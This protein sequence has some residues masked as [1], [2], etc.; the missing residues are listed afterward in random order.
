MAQL[1][2]RDNGELFIEHNVFTV[3]DPDVMDDVPAE[4]DENGLLAVT[5]CGAAVLCGT[6]TGTIEVTAETWDGSPPLDPSS[7]Q[8]V[9]EMTLPW[10]GQRMEV[11]GA[12]YTPDEE[13]PLTIPG[14]GTYRLRVCG[15]HRDDGEDR[16]TAD[17]P[18]EQYLLQIWPAPSAP[19]VTHK[20]T[21][22]LGA[23]WRSQPD[24]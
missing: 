14:P 24:T 5:D 20:A 2:Q 12:G 13:L 9:T 7:W 16:R 6:H 15:R 4:F 17:T 23:R 21:S 10:K 18:V 19:P 8:D 22:A 1:I 3:L 11:W